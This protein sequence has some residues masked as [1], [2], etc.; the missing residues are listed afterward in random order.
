MQCQ[1]SST[2][3]PGVPTSER[4]HWRPSLRTPPQARATPPPSTLSGCRLELTP[5]RC[6]E[7]GCLAELACG[8]DSVQEALLDAAE[9]EFAMP[10][11]FGPP[12]WPVGH[13][14]SGSRSLRPRC[15]QTCLSHRFSSQPEPCEAE[16]TW[17]LLSSSCAGPFQLV[18]PSAD[19]C[20][21][22]IS[23]TRRGRALRQRHRPADM[24][25]CW[26]SA[27]P[28]ARHCGEQR[29]TQRLHGRTTPPTLTATLPNLSSP[30]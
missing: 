2:S 10:S 9:P 1:D 19:R 26:W 29:I 18:M 4:N 27:P 28:L 5:T 13:M 17:S 3:D 30:S 22:G 6:C 15:I 16:A 23:P 7:D 21:S 8:R 12:M 11:G 20:A 25:A 14:R 24:G